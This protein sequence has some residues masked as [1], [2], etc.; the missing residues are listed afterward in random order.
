MI[1][2]QSVCFIIL[3]MFVRLWC[4]VPWQPVMFFYFI[5]ISGVFVSVNLYTVH[6]SSL[7]RGNKYFVESKR[8]FNILLPKSF[9]L[10]P[11]TMNNNLKLNFRPQRKALSYPFTFFFL[12]T[13]TNQ[14]DHFCLSPMVSFFHSAFW[15]EGQSFLW[16]PVGLQWLCTMSRTHEVEKLAFCVPSGTMSSYQIS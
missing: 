7:V 9:N 2:Y 8:I 15:M 4:L 16:K 12:Y 6:V 11:W 14:R 13:V 10:S 1:L 3:N 5:F